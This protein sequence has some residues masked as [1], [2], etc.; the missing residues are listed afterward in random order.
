ME[1]LDTSE[2][3]SALITL[4]YGA[5]DKLYTHVEIHPSLMYGFMGNQ[6]VYPE[7]NPLPRNAFACGQ[8]KQAVSL[9]STNFF[10]ASTKWES[11]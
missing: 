7:N 10:L 4:S 8:A 1:Y 3:E 9:Y 6:I 2:A 11:F 5:R